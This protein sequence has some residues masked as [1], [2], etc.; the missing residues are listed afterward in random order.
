M[1]EFQAADVGMPVSARLRATSALLSRCHLGVLPANTN[2]QAPAY[3]P[4]RIP[5]EAVIERRPMRAVG[6]NDPSMLPL[7]VEAGLHFLRMLEQQ[8]PSQS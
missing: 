2:A 4:R 5:L 7:A 1:G 3:D 8:A 6:P